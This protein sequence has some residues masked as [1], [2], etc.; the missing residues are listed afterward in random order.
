MV[1]GWITKN[2]VTRN[3]SLPDLIAMRRLGQQS[4]LLQLQA[5]LPGIVFRVDYDR[6]QQTFASD[7]G[8]F[9]LVQFLV[10][11]FTQQLA[12]S[13]GVLDESF[14]LQDVQCGHADRRSQRVA[15]VGAAVFAR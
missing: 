1:S 11:Q 6:V 12:L 3:P 2:L 9:A 8:D 15:S 5:D 7:L 13:F 4:V 10:Q 14:V